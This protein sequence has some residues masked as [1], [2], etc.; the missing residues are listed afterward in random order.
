MLKSLCR[1]DDGE[2]GDSTTSHTKILCN[3]IKTTSEIIIISDQNNSQSKNLGA[4]KNK[5]KSSVKF[6][7]N[8]PIDAS[9]ANRRRSSIKYKIIQP[10]DMIRK[11]VRKNSLKFIINQPKNGTK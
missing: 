3:N 2:G 8:E 4:C 11:N 5:R 9:S 7:F 1:T 10:D 6:E